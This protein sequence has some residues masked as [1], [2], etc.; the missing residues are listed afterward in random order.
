[1]QKIIIY[2]DGSCYWKNKCGGIGVFLQY[3]NNTKEI[4]K[5]FQNTTISKMELSAI[6]VALRAVKWKSNPTVIY[7]DSQY[8]VNSINLWARRWRENGWSDRANWQLLDKILDEVDKFSD[9]QIIWCKGHADIAGNEK[10]DSLA[11]KA[12]NKSKQKYNEQQNSRQNQ[13]A[14]KKSRK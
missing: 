8:A 2:T 6:L 10:A 13:K 14:A 1:M 3:G 12:Y 5:D 7:S 4:S 9:L 11:R